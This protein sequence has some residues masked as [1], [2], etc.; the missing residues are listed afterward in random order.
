MCASIFNIYIPD[1][2]EYSDV[3][4]ASCP[5]TRGIKYFINFILDYRLV[6]GEGASCPCN[7]RI[8]DYRVVEGASCPCNRRILDYRVVEGLHASVIG[9]LNIF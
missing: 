2:V 9:G 1:S 5:C 4:G 8:L 3:K 7:R 6:E